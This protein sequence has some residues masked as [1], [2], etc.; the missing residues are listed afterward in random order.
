MVSS[1]A[2]LG[3]LLQQGIGDTIRISVTPE[4]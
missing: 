1:A 4:P 3:I 2:A